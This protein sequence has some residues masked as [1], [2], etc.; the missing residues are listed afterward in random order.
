MK[1]QIAQS[2][3]VQEHRRENFAVIVEEDRYINDDYLLRVTHNGLQWSTMKL[4]KREMALVIE[5]LAR[6]LAEVAE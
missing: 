6:K 1:T 4:N 5:A 3:T 2:A